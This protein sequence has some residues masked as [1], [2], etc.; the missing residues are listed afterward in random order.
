MK[1]SRNVD[2]TSKFWKVE[3]IG[4]KKFLCLYTEI[5]KHDDQT[6]D[7]SWYKKLKDTIWAK[8][9]VKRIFPSIISILISLLQPEVLKK[10]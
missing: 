10:F 8:W 4:S 2:N 5:I 7:Y 6:P 3:W 1:V 9:I